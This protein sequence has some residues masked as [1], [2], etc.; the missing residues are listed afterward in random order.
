METLSENN[1]DTDESKFNLENLNIEKRQSVNSEEIREVLLQGSNDVPESLNRPVSPVASELEDEFS[2]IEISDQ[3]NRDYKIQFPSRP[4]SV[5][6]LSPY[7]RPLTPT[8]IVVFPPEV[9]SCFRKR[10]K[11]STEEVSSLVKTSNVTYSE[12]PTFNK[13]C[14]EESEKIIEERLEVC[15][16]NITSINETNTCEIHE[17]VS[18]EN[19]PSPKYKSGNIASAMTVAPDRPFTPVELTKA[20][21]TLESV[22]L[23]NET[24][25]YFY[26]NEEK[27]Q[28]ISSEESITKSDKQRPSL[29]EAL[30][31]APKKSYNISS[32]NSEKLSNI[33]AKKSENC[34]VPS[35][36]F[37]PSIILKKEI[38][39]KSA[40]EKKESEQ[41]KTFVKYDGRNFFPPI[42]DELKAKFEH[43]LRTGSFSEKQNRKSFIPTKKEERSS[44]LAETRVSKTPPIVKCHQFTSTGLHKPLDLP[45]YQQCVREMTNRN[46]TPTLSRRNTPTNFGRSSL[47]TTPTNFEATVC[48]Q[49][50]TFHS[51]F[52]SFE[53]KLQVSEIAVYTEKKNSNNQVMCIN[54]FSSAED[55]KSSQTQKTSAE[56][57]SKEVNE[58][59]E[60][61]P[62][63]QST[64]P[65]IDPIIS[66]SLPSSALSLP[67]SK[68][69][70][71]SRLT[72]TLAALTSKCHAS[73][74][75]KN[76]SCV[77][78]KTVTSSDPNPVGA[79]GSGISNS[80]VSAGFSA[81]RRGK[82][83]WNPQNL[84]PGARIP[85]CAH[86]N[87]QIR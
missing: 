31:I 71:S 7:E 32:N 39:K 16:E 74:T 21:I 69:S 38:P 83:V 19:L 47:K 85:L 62:I 41:F 75:S 44:N 79:R 70:V 86:C 33:E 73:N 13:C 58:Q 63:V 11:S 8:Q 2:S 37:D 45:H 50:K 12:T 46:K 72:K 30:S 26:S 3:I 17:N 80:G 25:P 1:K 82:G 20:F 52:S 28:M 68:S 36:S 48:T 6:S 23:P 49:Q 57:Q 76:L 64:V 67:L 53:N 40:T 60:F 27:T 56:S 42:T 10:E 5:R 77:T 14:T 65:K 87:A 9:P 4:H 18:L 51:T 81:P 29:S 61:K 22:D 24:K 43:K 15:D 66:T 84:A 78:L 34:D 59:V 35:L 55:A 54:Q